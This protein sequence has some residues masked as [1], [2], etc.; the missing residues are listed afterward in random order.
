M[1]EIIKK[2]SFN[3]SGTG[4]VTP[5]INLVN[6]WLSDMGVNDNEKEVVLSYNKE[7]KEILI[8]KK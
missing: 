8:K 1:K 5:K 4:G 3:K 6:E 7:S 2:V